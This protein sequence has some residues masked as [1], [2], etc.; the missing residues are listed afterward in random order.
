VAPGGDGCLNALGASGVEFDQV[1]SVRGVDTPVVV[2]SKIGN[3]SYYA[4]G[5]VPLLL[6]CRMAMTLV[7]IAPILR[8]H[9]VSKVRFSGA[10]VYRMSSKGR[11]SLHARGLA[12]DV[13]EV[14]AGGKTFSVTRDFKRGIGK[15]CQNHFPVLN[16]IACSLDRSGLFRELLTPDYNADHHDHFHIAI[17]PVSSPDAGGGAVEL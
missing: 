17:T 13:H 3:V 15:D 11:L 1:D 6:D 5:N 16:R 14:V 12:L 4:N 10:Y 8:E 7:T 9:G 2:T